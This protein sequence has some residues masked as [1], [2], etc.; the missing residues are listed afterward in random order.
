MSGRIYDTGYDIGPIPASKIDVN[1]SMFTGHLSIFDDNVQKALETLDQFEINSSL[2]EDDGTTHIKPKDSKKVNV[3]HIDGAF[4]LDQTTPQDVVP[5]AGTT[6]SLT[7]YDA[8]PNIAPNAFNVPAIAFTNSNALGIS[9]YVGA[10]R[11]GTFMY[12]YDGNDAVIGLINDV[13]ADQLSI[14]SYDSNNLWVDMTIQS[15]EFFDTPPEIRYMCAT[16][17]GDTVGYPVIGGADSDDNRVLLF[18]T[19]IGIWDSQNAGGVTLYGVSQDFSTMSVILQWFSSDR[20]S[21]V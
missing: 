15:G 20:K 2:W 14:M 3:E 5:Y 8:L 9:P 17:A 13:E 7:N 12:A 19:S 16:N 11:G 1:T 10:I 21:V 6:F 18:D 4:K